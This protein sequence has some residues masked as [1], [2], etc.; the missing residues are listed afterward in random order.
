M[1][2]PCSPDP[3]LRPPP[4]RLIRS[5]IARA[6]QISPHILSFTISIA[7]SLASFCV[8][9]AHHGTVRQAFTSPPSNPELAMWT[10]AGINAALLASFPILQDRQPDPGKHQTAIT[11]AASSLLLTAAVL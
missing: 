4:R 10:L 5:T 3:S 9:A 1:S 2:S 7:S 11:L 8:S 6:D